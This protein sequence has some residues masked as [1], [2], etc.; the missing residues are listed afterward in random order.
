M[1]TTIQCKRRLTERTDGRKVGSGSCMVGGWRDG[2][3]GRKVKAMQMRIDGKKGER[4]RAAR[5]ERASVIVI[6]FFFLLE[7]DEET[8]GESDSGHS[9]CERINDIL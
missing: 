4:E 5:L 9:L 2:D 6:F 7:S 3:D 8:D 1:A